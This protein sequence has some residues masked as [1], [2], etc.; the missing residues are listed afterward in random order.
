MS[1]MVAQCVRAL[2]Q[3]GWHLRGLR[4]EQASQTLEII[5]AI[6]PVFIRLS[7]TRHGGP[8]HQQRPQIDATK[9]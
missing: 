1:L 9:V 4:T 8:I 2:P 6:G 7:W 5:S 3:P